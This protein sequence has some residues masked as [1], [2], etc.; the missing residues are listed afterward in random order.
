M[1]LQD[2][3]AI[4]FMRRRM[5]EGALRYRAEYRREGFGFQRRMKRRLLEMAL[6]YRRQEHNPQHEAA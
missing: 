2:P 3:E 5:I 4:R 1:S 6:E